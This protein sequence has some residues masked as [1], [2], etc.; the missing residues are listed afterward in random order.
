METKWWIHKKKSECYRRQ[1]D[2][3]YFWF[4]IFILQNL[5]EWKLYTILSIIF[6]RRNRY[7]KGQ[8]KLKNSIKSIKKT[9]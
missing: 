3:E 1:N 4:M 2:M 5:G 6:F 9:L 7:Y 8:G